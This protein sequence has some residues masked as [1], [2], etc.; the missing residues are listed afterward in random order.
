MNS[1]H[2]AI[3][4]TISHISDLLDQLNQGNELSKQEC[5]QVINDL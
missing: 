2:E 1:K 3:D 4:L 5:L